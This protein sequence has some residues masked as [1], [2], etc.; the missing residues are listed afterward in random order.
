MNWADIA[1]L[2]II[3]I[4]VIIS[5]FRGFLREALSLLVW[6]MAF[7]IAW[8]F[9]REL[10]PYFAQWVSAPS[11]QMALA[12]TAIVIGV[13][14][15]GGLITWVIGSLVDKTGLSGTD[16]VV[17]LLF[18]A[19]RG[20]IIIAIVVMMAGVTP[21]PQDPWWK[22]SQ[23]IPHFETVAIRLKEMLPEDIGQYLEFSDEQ[24]ATEPDK[25]ASQQNGV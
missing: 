1:I 10:A 4:S 24:P 2:S 14:I 13:V 11:L 3:G 5:F 25:T 16:R 8:T 7:W 9:F 22:Q 23:L 12:F 17:G 18:G 20:V 21:F 19:A 6:V 15:I